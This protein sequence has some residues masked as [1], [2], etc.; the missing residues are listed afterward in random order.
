[1]ISLADRNGGEPEAGDIHDVEV[2]FDRI[3]H[4]DLRIEVVGALGK[5]ST[6]GAVELDGVF[7]DTIFNE[8]GF[9]VAWTARAGASHLSLSGSTAGIR[10][11][12]AG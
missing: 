9:D 3:V 7:A 4:R 11:G 6:A 8:A 12:R 5:L 1:M 10:S 2:L